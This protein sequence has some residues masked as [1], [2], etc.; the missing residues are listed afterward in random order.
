MKTVFAGDART[1][2]RVAFSV[3][4]IALSAKMAKADGIVT[5]EEVRAFQDVFQVPEREFDN[6]ARLYNLARQDVTGYDAYARQVRSL[7]PGESPTDEEVLLDV[8]DALFHIAKADSVLHDDEIV[9]LQTI[10]DTF[11]F[12]RLTFERVRARH[13]MGG[14]GDPFAV[15]GAD[16]SM[17]FENIRALYRRHVAENHPDRLIAR[18][19]PEEFVNVAADR[20]AALNDAWARIEKLHRAATEQATVAQQDPAT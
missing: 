3:A 6:V 8:L 16:P 20:T 5:P 18:G 9:F 1:R 7:F 19:M 15:L 13:V 11:G 10:S 4:I 14:E 12:D 17:P 2:R